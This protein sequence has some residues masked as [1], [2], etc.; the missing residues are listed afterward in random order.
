MKFNIPQVHSSPAFFSL[1]LL[2]EQFAIIIFR[3]IELQLIKYTSFIKQRR[4]QKTW[5]PDELIKVPF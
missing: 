5:S 3:E 4:I 1:F 2:C